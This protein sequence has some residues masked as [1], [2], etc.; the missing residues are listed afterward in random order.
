VNN[1]SSTH[2][3][4]IEIGPASHPLPASRFRTPSTTSAVSSSYRR[5]GSFG[6]RER[7]FKAA[8]PS[9]A[10]RSRTL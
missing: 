5:A 3:C 4:Q 8:L 6:A 10:N 1:P 2:A 7:G 9:F